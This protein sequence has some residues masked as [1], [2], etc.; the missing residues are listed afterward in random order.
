MF[1]QKWGILGVSDHV[2]VSGGECVCF[3][4]GRA[5]VALSRVRVGKKK[6]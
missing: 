5:R 4:I 3:V 2:G 1:D 6:T